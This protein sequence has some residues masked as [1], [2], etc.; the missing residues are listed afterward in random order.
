MM[1]ETIAQYQDLEIVEAFN[2]FYIY[3]KDGGCHG[4]GD[5]LYNGLTPPQMQA[6]LELNYAEYLEAYFPELNQ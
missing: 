2:G 3:H 4:M 5:A 1:A 6:E